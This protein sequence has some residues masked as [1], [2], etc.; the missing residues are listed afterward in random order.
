[1]MKT[2]SVDIISKYAHELNNNSYVVSD[3]KKAHEANSE[4][5]SDEEYSNLGALVSQLMT[6]VIE[7]AGMDSYEARL[8]GKFTA[9]SEFNGWY[10]EKV[11]YENAEFDVVLQE[12]IE[13]SP[14]VSKE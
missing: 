2:I 9:L 13:K 6:K 8:S 11:L 3:L 12:Y 5:Y 7:D 14:F 4:D 1:M 10:M